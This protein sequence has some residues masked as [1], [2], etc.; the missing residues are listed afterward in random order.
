MDTCERKL[1]LVVFSAYYSVIFIF[2]SILFWLYSSVWVLFVFLDEFSLKVY[3]EIVR[4]Q[5]VN[6]CFS[7]LHPTM[8]GPGRT[9]KKIIASWFSKFAIFT[10][11][12]N[13]FWLLRMIWW[14]EFLDYCFSCLSTFFEFYILAFI[15]FELLFL[16]ITQWLGEI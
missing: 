7:E 11:L 2:D 15:I 9:A 14:F 10:I 8:I 4:Q 1:M 6:W 3:S 12:W 5:A 13:Y 16:E